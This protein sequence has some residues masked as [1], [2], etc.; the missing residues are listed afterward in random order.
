MW[1]WKIAPALATGNT[2]VLKVSIPLLPHPFSHI[3][4][5]FFF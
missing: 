1:A 5:T 4:H 3:F 2:I